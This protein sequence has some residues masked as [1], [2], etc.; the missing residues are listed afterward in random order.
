MGGQIYTWFLDLASYCEYWR[1]N[2][3]VRY[4]AAF[5]A[6]AKFEKPQKRNPHM[7]N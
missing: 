6:T 4:R 3:G 1:P 7:T 5:G 2:R